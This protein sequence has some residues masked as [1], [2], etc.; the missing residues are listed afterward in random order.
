MARPPTTEPRVAE[1]IAAWR[2]RPST[3]F[4]RGFLRLNLWKRQ[5]EILDAVS[6]Y[7][8]V[9]VPSCH[10]SGKTFVASVAAVHWLLSYQPSKV[11]TTAPGERQVKD[12][13]WA[14]I[15]ARHAQMERITK[16]NL[17]MGK[18]ATKEWRIPGHPDWFA[19]GF[20]TT[21]DTATEN[22]TR[23]HGYHSP[24]L[25]VILDEAGG[26]D[27]PVWSGVDGLLT[28]QGAHVLAIGQPQ[29]GSEFERVCR[30][31][32]WHVMRISA[33]DCPNLQEGSKQ[34]S[35]GVTR[36][37]A[38]MM[39]RKWGPFSPV[40][41]SKVLGLFPET[42]T[43]T[44][45]SLQD[46]ERA[47]GR[48]PPPPPEEPWVAIGCD[49]ARF[50][51][52]MTVIYVIHGAEILTVERWSGQDTMKT[53]GRII[54]LA[55]E[56]GL[57]RAHGHRIAVDDTGVGGGVTDRLHELGWPSMAVNF[58]SAPTRLSSEEKF[59]NRRTELWW[60]LREWIRHEA[61]LSPIPEDERDIIR[62]DLAAPKYEQKSD[63][64]IALEPKDDIRERTG[65]SPDDGDALAL[66]VSAQRAAPVYRWENW[67]GSLKPDDER[68]RDDRDKPRATGLRR[69]IHPEELYP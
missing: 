59:A 44:L 49:V 7:K 52:D 41:L 23:M 30:S 11:I 33:F 45:I 21:P 38:D 50:G 27:R 10:E 37:W 48:A 9:A 24:H 54:A 62:S 20:A 66:A 18:P 25:L 8:R 1:E 43:D 31:P 35:W 4:A 40:Y 14:E 34:R 42:S 28:G 46:I 65:R 2:E 69:R 5:R 63:G 26:L 13:L 53:A 64:R 39:L 32:D 3:A 57:D 29:G 19:T 47:F 51:H 16:G 56:Y 6:K 12:L 22:A 15:R 67:R 61:A 68:R 58:G 36:E 60:D 55:L 17:R